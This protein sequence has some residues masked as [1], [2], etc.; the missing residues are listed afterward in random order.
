MSFT[1]PSC[2]INGGTIPTRA[3]VAPRWHDEHM[4]ATEQSRQTERSGQA[5]QTP[6]RQDDLEFAELRVWLAEVDQNARQVTQHVRLLHC[7]AEQVVQ[8]SICARPVDLSSLTGEE[9][10]GTALEAIRRRLE[11]VSAV[12]L[13]QLDATHA[14]ESS[15][16]CGPSA[17]RPTAHMHRMR[18]SHAN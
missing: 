7:V 15:A 12:A 10:M 11:A 1:F 3:N 14:T 17:G 13:G 2:R 6:R 8:G 9:L 5:V 16:A 4:F 18:P